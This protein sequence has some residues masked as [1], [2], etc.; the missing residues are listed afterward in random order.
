MLAEKGDDSNRAIC[1]NVAIIARIIR[2]S[3]PL[4]FVEKSNSVLLRGLLS[5]TV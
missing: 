5:E 1:K 2:Y 3:E 4:L